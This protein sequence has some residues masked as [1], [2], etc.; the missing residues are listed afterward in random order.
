[1]ILL[2]TWLLDRLF[3][4]GATGPTSPISSCPIH[5]ISIFFGSSQQFLWLLLGFPFFSSRK[6]PRMWQFN[7]DLMVRR[8]CPRLISWNY[9]GVISKP[10]C[11]QSCCCWFTVLGRHLKSGYHSHR[12]SQGGTHQLRDSP[13]ESAPPDSKRTI[14]RSWLVH[15]IARAS[16]ILWNSAWARRQ[17]M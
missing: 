8:L 9:C 15:L 3:T 5:T 2:C 12:A 7:S 14:H 1:M 4:I 17:K 16:K 6:L 10:F 11:R 13:Y